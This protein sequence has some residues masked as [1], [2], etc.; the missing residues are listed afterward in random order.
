MVMERCGR[1]KRRLVG[2]GGW[3]VDI[4]ESCSKAESGKDENVLQN[5]CCLFD[6][7]VAVQLNELADDRDRAIA[8]KQHTRVLQNSVFTASVPS[9]YHPATLAIK[10]S[11]SLYFL[12]ATQLSALVRDLQ[13]NFALVFAP[14]FEVKLC[15]PEWSKTS[16]GLLG[17]TYRVM[18]KH[19]SSFISA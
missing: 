14:V 4:I 11:V 3:G 17:S 19:L 9:S 5:Q 12:Y 1:R 18:A 2:I 13:L 6:V 7:A 8:R 10:L 15:P 16:Q